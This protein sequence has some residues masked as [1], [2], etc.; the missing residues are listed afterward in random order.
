[1]KQENTQKI[2]FENYPTIFQEI[3]KEK[4]IEIFEQAKKDWSKP[5]CSISNKLVKYG[6]CYYFEQKK[7]D[8]IT[9]QSK[10]RP[11][12]INHSKQP[13]IDM[14]DF[15]EIGAMKTGRLQRLNAIINVLKDLKK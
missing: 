10:L 3:K 13:L 11:L 1:M 7:I 2:D 6:L 5:F 9:I 15:A 12:W 14:F 4:L 8:F